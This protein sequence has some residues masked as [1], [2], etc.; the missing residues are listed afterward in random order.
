MYLVL[1]F[2]SVAVMEDMKW[3]WEPCYLQYGDTTVLN[4]PHNGP[5]SPHPDSYL[6]D[7]E[8]QWGVSSLVAIVS[9]TNLA[10]CHVVKSLLL[11]SRSGTRRWNLRVPDLH[12]SCSDLT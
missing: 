11:I 10:P 7:T 12:M 3:E 6:E 4:N 8:E 2:P 1:G 9:T 5:C